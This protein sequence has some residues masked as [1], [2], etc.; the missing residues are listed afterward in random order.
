MG[1]LD[2]RTDSWLIAGKLSG[3]TCFLVTS[4]F[5]DIQKLLVAWKSWK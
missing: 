4:K 3:D 5:P 1:I 2:G